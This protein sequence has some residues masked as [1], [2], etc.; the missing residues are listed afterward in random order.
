ML[1]HARGGAAARVGGLG[2]HPWGPTHLLELGDLVLT[3][4]VLFCRSGVAAICV[5]VRA[6]K[7]PVGAGRGA[8][9]RH[10]SVGAKCAAL[11][12]HGDS[13][14]VCAHACTARESGL[15]MR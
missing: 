6:R 5:C 8:P 1:C 14:C 15:F 12:C 13:V 4:R 11:V 9:R 7:R 3:S 2:T 10:N